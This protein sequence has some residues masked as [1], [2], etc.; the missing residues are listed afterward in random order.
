MN[1]EAARQVGNPHLRLAAE[2]TQDLEGPVEGLHLVAQC[3]TGAHGTTS[4]ARRQ[5]AGK[6]PRFA[7]FPLTPAVL[8]ASVRLRPIYRWCTADI[9]EG[10]LGERTHDRSS[11]AAANRGCAAAHGR[12]RERLGS[13]ARTARLPT[14]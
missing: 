2:Q 8:G 5:P 7:G 6:R 4:V 9:R 12:P 3:K 11:S 13:L 14:D 1:L 10:K